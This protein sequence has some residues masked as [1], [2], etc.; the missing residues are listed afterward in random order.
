MFRV[1]FSHFSSHLIFWLRPSQFFR[2]V[3]PTILVQFFSF[4]KPDLL[5]FWVSPSHLSKSVLPIFQVRPSHFFWVSPSHFL[6]TVIFFIFYLIFWASPF[7]Y[8]FRERQ[9]LPFLGSPLHFFHSVFPFFGCQ[10]FPH[11]RVRPSHFFSQPFPLFSSQSIPFL[12]GHAFPYIR[13]RSFHFFGS[14]FP[15]YLAHFSL[16]SSSSFYSLWVWLKDVEFEMSTENT[17]FNEETCLEEILTV[18]FMQGL[19]TLKF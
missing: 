19:G 12:G 13:V 14:V 3:L 8:F 2:A 17:F 6:K 18:I 5:I 4:L 16:S 7:H 1:R 9:S 11:F 15:F 10:A